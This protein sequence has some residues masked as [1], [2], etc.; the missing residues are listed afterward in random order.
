MIKYDPISASSRLFGRHDTHFETTVGGHPD[1]TDQFRMSF[2]DALSDFRIVDVSKGGLGLRSGIYRPRNLRLIFVVRGS[3]EGRIELSRAL[4]IRVIG[5]R[6]SLFDHRPSYLLGLQVWD[7]AGRDEWQ[8]VKFALRLEDIA[9]HPIASETTAR[10]TQPI[11]G[12]SRDQLLALEALPPAQVQTCEAEAQEVGSDLKTVIRGRR[13]LIET[14]IQ[15]LRVIRLGG[16]ITAT[17][18]T[19]FP[20]CK[21]RVN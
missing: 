16:H 2:A 8:L 14:S 13:E 19:S 7:V 20:A 9:K 1:E 21:S 11:R 15:A 10:G 3:N 5:R 17:C 4:I 12:T 6:C 18:P